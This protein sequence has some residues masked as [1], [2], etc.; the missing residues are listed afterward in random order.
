VFV[1][2]LGTAA[3]GGLPQWNCACGVC[4]LARSDPARV[5]PRT[6]LCAA[7]S[8]DGRRWFLLNAS[9][10]LRAQVE[11]FPPLGPRGAARGSGIEGILLTGADL[12][13]TLGLLLLR[14]SG[15]LVVHASPAVRRSLD[16]GL[17]LTA[18]LGRYSAVEWREPPAAPAPLP[19]AAGAPSGLLYA[20]FAAPGK[21]P[22]YREGEVCPEAGDCVGYHLIDPRTGGWLVFLPGVA[23]LDAG[24]LAACGG[25]DVL[26]L[27]G[28]FWSDGELT[29]ACGGASASAMGHLSVGGPGGS[30]ARAAGLAART[31]YVHVNNTNPMLLE[32]SPQRRAVE[33]AGAEVGQDGME[34][35]L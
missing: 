13:A 2:L 9:P 23:S 21:P 15:R 26:L 7:V 22:R 6:Q 32:D 3:G 1:R 14:E 20:A 34:F 27:D 17:R 5:R 18:V 4:A 29:E 12:D 33:A 28:T 19:D 24:V 10:D 16:E 11:S 35:H 8:A 31:V 30:L 25:A